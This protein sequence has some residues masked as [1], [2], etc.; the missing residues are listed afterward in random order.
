MFSHPP[1]LDVNTAHALFDM[2]LAFV[3]NVV[4]DAQLTHQG[5]GGAAQVVRGLAAT[6]PR[7]RINGFSPVLQAGVVA[8]LMV[9]Q[10]L[11]KR[12]I[13]R[14]LGGGRVSGACHQ[15]N[16]SQLQATILNGGGNC[17][18]N[19]KINSHKPQWVSNH[20]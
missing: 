7:K 19:S 9:S 12:L 20:N 8:A 17:G 13:T 2:V 16:K 15:I 18:G 10:L 11:A 4:G 5:G 1:V 3:D 14:I 6:N